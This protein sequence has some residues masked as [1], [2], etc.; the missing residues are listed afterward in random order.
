MPGWPGYLVVASQD[1][2]EPLRHA[3]EQVVADDVSQHVVHA[4]EV[5]EVHEQHGQSMAVCLRGLYRLLE[6]VE[7][8]GAVRQPCESVLLRQFGDA[9]IGARPLFAQCQRQLPYFVG[10][11]RLL[12]VEELVGRRD[13]PAD[14]GRV[15]VGVGGADDDLHLLVDLADLL[16]RPDAVGTGRH[17]HVEEC[18]GEGSFRSAGFPN[19]CYGCFCAVAVDGLEWLMRG[20]HASHECGIAASHEQA[21]PQLVECCAVAAGRSGVQHLSVCVEHWLLVVDDQHSNLFPCVQCH[22]QPQAALADAADRCSGT[23]T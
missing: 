17:A 1:L 11:K 9:A 2:A 16:C 6:A 10:M 5:V 15:H 13:S 18:H 14:V 22:L 4:P 20:R 3:P 19:R 23:V 12:Q 8:A 7:E 21:R